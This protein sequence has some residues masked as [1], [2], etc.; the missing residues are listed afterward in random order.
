MLKPDF[1]TVI[2]Q[3][4]AFAQSS[5]YAGL[6]K[7]EQHEAEEIIAA[8]SLTAMLKFNEQLDLLS[9][10]E[11]DALCFNYAP[12]GGTKKADA[13][14][15]PGLVLAYLR[16]IR[17]PALNQFTVRLKGEKDLL[18]AS[19]SSG[20]DLKLDALVTST[21]AQTTSDS[22]EQG[23]QL[24]KHYLPLWLALFDDDSL[25]QTMM[26]EA[27]RTHAKK[28]VTQFFQYFAQR[29]AQT[30][31][32]A[33][34]AEVE[35]AIL[36]VIPAKS[37]PK[38]EKF[39]RALYLLLYLVGRNYNLKKPLIRQVYANWSQAV[40]AVLADQ[41]AHWD[42]QFFKDLQN[43]VGREPFPYELKQTKGVPDSS[44]DMIQLFYSQLLTNV[45]V[46]SLLDEY[47]MDDTDDDDDLEMQRLQPNF[48][49]KLMIDQLTD[50]LD[51]LIADNH[52]QVRDDGY[53]R[54]TLK[55]MPKK[56]ETKIMALE[57]ERRYWVRQY[58]ID[59]FLLFLPDNGLTQ[60]ER[61]MAPAL[62][63]QLDTLVNRYTPEALAGM[64]ATGWNF[65]S[66][67]LLPVANLSPDGVKAVSPIM[68]AFYDFL[69]ANDFN[70]HG[71]Q[72]AKIIKRDA[73]KLK[74]YLTDDEQRMKATLFL[75]LVPV[76]YGNINDPQAY[77]DYEAQ[78]GLFQNDFEDEDEG[79]PAFEP[80]SNPHK[81]V[82]FKKKKSKKRKKK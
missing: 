47:D 77:Q 25:M 65:F 59:E 9:V 49:P 3:W 51:K 7:Y 37:Q 38:L 35:A 75:M 1:Q 76:D 44:L 17:W 42:K 8:L 46:S 28:N 16:Y 58:L 41:G 52:L 5:E 23:A 18:A 22:V 30:P 27:E 15:F 36:A 62:I 4:E 79:Q 78:L 71:R 67:V 50:Q 74:A 31:F 39:C 61:S 13:K 45:D 55:K 82:S 20:V 66:R 21:Q 34:A 69:E 63:Q 72:I 53:G 68:A 81:I 24:A 10:E 2:D 48:P 57:D 11:M 60:T 29:P 12:D 43:G 73:T 80:K 56:L 26:T 70:P 32:Q 40:A 6:Y 33:S 14:A 64:N 19:Q 54:M